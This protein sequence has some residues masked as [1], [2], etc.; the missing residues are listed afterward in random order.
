MSAHTDAAALLRRALAA[1]DASSV[2]HP[3]LRS[4]VLV[5]MAH[6]VRASGDGDFTVPFREAVSLARAHGIG[7]V[8]ARAAR[9]VSSMPGT[10]PMAG[11]REVLEAAE[12]ALTQD[13]RGLRADV[14]ARLAWTPPYSLDA[15]QSAALAG[16]AEALARESGSAAALVSAL[17]AKLYLDTGPD[18]TDLGETIFDEVDGLAGLP[19]HRRAVWAAHAQFAR[20]VVS[21]QRGN[22]PETDRAIAHFGEAAR[23]LRNVELQWHHDRARAVQRMNVAGFAGMSDVLT[24]L[25]RRVAGLGL[26]GTE[27]LCAVDLGV[28]LRESGGAEALASFESRIVVEE[29]DPPAIRARKIR[30]LAELGALGR[31]RAALRPMIAFL[32]RLPHNRDY[33]ATLAHLAVASIATGGSEETERVYERLK[34]YPGLYVADISLHTDGSVSRFLGMLA[35]ALNRAR[36]ATAHFEEALARNERAGLAPQAARARHD[37]AQALARTGHTK[38][39]RALAVQVLEAS[40]KLGMP[41]LAEATR[42]LVR[43]LG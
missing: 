10:I 38:R 41:G 22:I 12:A 33:L 36:D 17:A 11:A 2:G 15:A 34:P 5:E 3:R 39:A 30:W 24:D 14:L 26:Q 29:S 35:G 18:S 20:M 43:G 32:E 25:R 19:P 13:Q 6:C 21:L 9:Y 28:L 4:H 31:A 23:E 42:I 1:L 27:T 8:L 37:L 40:P 7:E 16:R